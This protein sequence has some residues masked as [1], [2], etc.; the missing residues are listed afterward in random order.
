MPKG[1]FTIEGEIDDFTR[2]DNIYRTLKRE[3]EKLLTKWKISFDIEYEETQGEG[4]VV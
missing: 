4:E 1:K 3:G 2:I